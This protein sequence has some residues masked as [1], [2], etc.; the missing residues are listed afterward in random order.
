M[1]VI[2]IA[3]PYRAYSQDGEIS[4]SGIYENINRA[5][6]VAK[7]VWR[8]GLVPLTPHLNS[9]LMDGF[10]KDEVFLRGD[11]ELLSRSDAILLLP[12][13][14]R[15]SGATGEYLHA[16]KLKIP[17]FSLESNQDQEITSTLKRMSDRLS[18]N[19]SD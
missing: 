10:C 17:H 14:E 5:R 15:S 7:F 13:W 1:K 12:D 3:G 11:L 8:E 4:I 2:Y 19:T 16:L 18:E 6:F 9:M